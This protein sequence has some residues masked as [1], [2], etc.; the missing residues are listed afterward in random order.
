MVHD[1]N[2]GAGIYSLRLQEIVVEAGS[3]NGILS[4]C[5]CDT[6]D[7]STQLTGADAGGSW[8]ETIP[9][10]GFNDPIWS[11]AGLAS[12]VYS[13]EYNVVDGCATDSVITNIE[14]FAPSYAGIDGTL[15][16]CQ[17][18]PISLWNGLV[19]SVGV[20]FTGVWYDALTSS[21]LP[22]ADITAEPFP[23]QYNYQYIAGNGICIDD[24]SIVTVTVASNCDFL[25]L[26]DL[27]FEGMDLYPNPTT[28][29]FYISNE[30]STDVYNY[31]LT[32]LNGKI[33]TTKE[34][35]ITGVETTEVNVEGL[36][37]GVY[38]IRIF[39]NNAEKT[40]RVVKQ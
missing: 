16:V 1:P 12:Q 13:F 26:Q 3:D 25:N 30:G 32:D 29:V 6:V 20:D 22:N 38:L 8:S 21:A 28:N 4:V 9:T 14:V 19:G 2:G 17:N 39:N 10:A 18:E 11:S 37:T 7:L 40:F 15:S 31:E 27:S 36:E 5:L 23:G 33:I 24:T 34:A 35:A